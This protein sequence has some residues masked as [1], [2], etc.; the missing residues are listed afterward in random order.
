MRWKLAAPSCV[1]PGRAGENCRVLAGLVDEAAL[2]LLETDSCLAYDDNDL[3]PDLPD[4][5]LSFHAHLPLDLP[6]AAGTDR[7]VR[8]L[9][10]LERKI[11]FLRPGA[12]V[13]HPPRPGGLSRLLAAYPGLA[14]RLC[15]EN[16][17]HGDLR[18]I[19]DEIV[20]L[21]LGVCL[22]LGH[23]TSYGQEKI[24]ELPGFFRRVRMLHVYGGESSGG[25]AELSTLPCPELLR[26]ILVCLEDGATI[27]VEVFR[28]EELRRSLALLHRW[29]EQWGMPAGGG[30]D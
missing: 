25:H 22:D 11:S 17:R 4:L 23:L 6:W 30:H 5:G 16:V 12:Y 13:L 2:M 24:L 18:D 20:A 29:L 3:P 8:V 21:N 10:G 14:S 19:W 28:L 7:V 1:I 26:D 27:V 15:L 9:R